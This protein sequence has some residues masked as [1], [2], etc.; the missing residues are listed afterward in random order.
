MTP[1]SPLTIENV[2]ADGNLIQF[3]P[4]FVTTG[5]T[6]VAP[7]AERRESTEGVLYR[8]DL[9]PSGMVGGYFEL[10]DISGR[11]YDFPVSPS[12]VT[13]NVNTG[14][15]LSNDYLLSEKAQNRARMIW[16]TD[17]KGDT[18]LFTKTFSTR[19]PF[20]FGLAGRFVNTVETVGDAEVI[21][22][23]VAEGGFRK[24]GVAG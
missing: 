2:L 6:T 22:N 9:D 16:R 18:G 8:C 21:V 19:I 23:I 13:N 5:V 24:F 17:F 1:W 4:E 15:T 12:L 14:V 20:V 7:G 11:P 10:W 3:F